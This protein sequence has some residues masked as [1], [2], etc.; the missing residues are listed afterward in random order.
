MVQA[1]MGIEF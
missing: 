1:L